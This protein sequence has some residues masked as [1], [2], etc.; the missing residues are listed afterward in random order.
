LVH[1]FK[2]LDAKVEVDVAFELLL[3]MPYSVSAPN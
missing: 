2:L 1:G 3:I